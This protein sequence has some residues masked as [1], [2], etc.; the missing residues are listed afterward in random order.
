MK[1]KFFLFLLLIFGTY[2]S[3]AQCEIN[4]SA[5]PSSIVC[6]E[7]AVLT[8]FGSSTGQLVLN[9]DFNSGGFGSGWNSTPGAVNFS[10]P[11]SS[12][13]IDGTTHAWMDNNTSVPRA[14]IS[15]GYDLSAATAGVSICFDMLF[16]TQGDAAPC[17]GPDEPDEGVYLQ[18]STDGGATWVTIHYFDPN[19]GNDPQLTNWNNWCFA[20]PAVAITSNTMFQWYQDADSGQD[21][22]HWGI[23]NV[24]IFMNDANAEVIWLHDG[25]SYG[26][27]NPGGDNPTPVTPTTTTTYTAQITTGSGDVCTADITVIVTDPVYDVTVSAN[28]TTIC[29]GDCATIVGSAQII[30][31]PGG[32]ET[33]ENSEVSVLSG[34]PS[35]SDIANIIAPCFSFS[36]CNCPD[37][38]SVSIGQSCPAIFDAT[39][40][41]NINVTTLN[42][43]TLPTSSIETVCIDFAQMISGDFSTY[44][45]NLI[46][47]DGTSILL[48]NIGDLSGTTLSNVCFDMSASSYI[49]SGSSPYT[50]SWLPAEP[51]GNLNGC[52]A[53]G[54]YTLQFSATYDYSSGVP[55]GGVATGVLNGWNITFDDPPIFA[56]VD[57]QWSPTTGLSDPTSINTD[58]CPTTSTDYTLTLSNGTPG[59]PIHEEV[60]SIIVNPCGGCVPPNLIISPLSACSP[61]TVDLNSAIGAGSDPANLTFYASQ[62][63]AQNDVNAISSVVGAS[64][65]YWV[66]AEDS[67]DPSCYMEYEIVV[68]I[69]SLSISVST[70][71]ENCGAGD[72][73]ISITVSNGSGNYEYSVDG[74]TTTQTGSSF[75]GL[76]A[77]TYSIV[78]NDLTTGCTATSTENISNLGGPS[79][80]NLAITDPSCAGVCDGSITATVSGGTPPYTYSWTDGS[81]SS[82]GTNSPTISGLCSGNYNLEVSDAAGGTTQ[83]FYDDF[84]TGATGWTLNDVMGA[85]GADPNYFVV[86][87]D[88]G[89]VAPGGCGVASNGDATLHV[90]SVFNPSGGAAYDAGGLCGILFCP[91]A[92]R[93]AETPLISTIGQTGLTLNFDYIAGGDIPND[94]ATVW[95]NDGFGWTQLGGA[96]FSGTGAC[97]PQ[98]VWTAFSSALPVSCENISNLQIAIRWQNNDDGAGSDPSVAI[99]NIEI[100]TNSAASCSA[101]QMATLTDPP[102]EDASFTLTDFCAGDVNAA[103]GIITPGGTFTFNPAPG[104]GSTINTSTG[105]IA[106]GVVG[107]TYTVEYTTPGSCSAS[108]TQ[109]VTVNGI[110]YTAVTNDENCGSADGSID[111]SASDGSGNYSY[112]IDNGG[113]TQSI[114][115]FSGLTSGVY[116]VV[117]TDVTN[118]C[119]ISGTENVGSIGGPSIDN[120]SV[121][122]PS[123]NGMCDGE[124]TVSVSGGQPPYTYQWYDGSGNQIG[125]NSPTITGLCGGNYSVEVSDANGG[126]S[127]TLNTNTGFETGS[128]A[129]CDCPTGYSCNN[130]AGQVFDGN[131]PVY[132]PGNTGCVGGTTNYT[133]SLGANGGSGYVYFYAG[134]DYLSTG[135]YTFA[136]GETVELCVYYSGPQGSG[137]SGQNT[138]NSNFSFGVDGTQVGPD[139]LVPVNTGW[140]QFCFTVTMTPGNHTFEIL[141]GGAAQYVIWFDDFTILDISGGGTNCPAN[142]NFTLTEPV[143]EDPSFN[144]TD[145]CAGESNGA[146]GIASPGGTF[147]FNPNPSDG[148]SINASTGEITNGVPG[149]TYTI[150]YTTS[151]TCPVNA[152][153]T[154][155]VNGFTYSSVVTD[156]TCSSAN[157]SI[158]LT[159]SGGGA[160]FEYSIDNGTTTQ[161]GNTFSN[162]IAGNYDVLIVDQSTGCSASGVETIANT[163]VPQIDVID[164]TDETCQGLNNGSIDVS[165]VSGGTGNYS[166][167]WDIIPDPG[168]AQV[169]NLAPGTYTVTVT[170][171]VS[172]CSTTSTQTINS[173]VNCCDMAIDQL[174]STDVLCNGGLDGTID[175]T[176][177][178]GNG[179]VTFE[180]TDGTYSDNNTTGNFVSVPV[181]TY[182]VTLTNINGCTDQSQVTVGEPSSVDFTWTAGDITCFGGADGSISI[183][184]SGGTPNY[185][186]S[187]D[188][189]MTWSANSDQL[190]L[191]QA[192][193][194]VL[195]EDAN[196]CQTNVQSVSLNEAAEILVTTTI[197]NETCFNQCDGQVDIAVSGGSGVYTYNV[198]GA[199]TG[200][201]VTG[202]CGGTINYIIEDDNGCMVTGT[203]DV[204]SAQQITIDNI[205]VIDDDCDNSCVGEIIITSAQA[206]NYTLGGN[207]NTSGLFTGLC[208]DNYT[209]IL[210]DANG[211]TVTTDVVVGAG[212]SATANFAVLPGYV[213]I[214]NTEFQVINNSTNSDGYLWEI[215]GPENYSYTDGSEEFSLELP[216][217]PG[218]YTVCLVAGNS[219]GCPD[220]ICQS[221]IVKDEFLLFVPNSFTPNGDEYNNDLQV[222]ATG[223][224]EYGFNMQIFDR[225]GELIWETNDIS[226]FWDG[227]YN[228]KVVQSGTYTWK[229]VIKDPY[230]DERRD[231]VGHINVLK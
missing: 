130:D 121:T 230:T 159:T 123:C 109:T 211:C 178:G 152:S 209:V 148:S 14:L 29:V 179:T 110:T 146:T 31:D 150:E 138:A 105:E 53:N 7:S 39:L 45:L 226:I 98:G 202:L 75:N 13:G 220:T 218:A 74:G 137:A 222:Y 26:V 183:N 165:S 142:A 57:V 35:V 118:G 180:I 36:G 139:V 95:Y 196:G 96:L 54:I 42:G 10:N 120:I 99:N 19:G 116:N 24:Q 126:T 90:T 147:A 228:G 60:I 6:G 15:D 103:S 11:C 227:T 17:E 100:V 191:S 132:T 46:C 127:T 68:T 200:S 171:N 16:A 166:Y 43:V 41:M 89:G 92:D 158:E 47:P 91:Q 162:L 225:W 186:Y 181:G 229:I 81:G 37:G 221:V 20:V 177:S 174:S 176:Y 93:Q 55:S 94:Q 201:N 88:E 172:G 12:S 169:T 106:N 213:T 48:A 163:A 136:G 156:E 199:N 79:I 129:S 155:S 157:G 70:V 30:V 173:G 219:M 73:Q 215:T 44:E 59:C 193:Y 145:F 62:A 107:T 135:P 124:I 151:G 161:T 214:M 131:Q 82:V 108:S 9:E 85:E 58:A 101:T 76:T 49:T 112:S 119:Q 102:L 115:T 38:S 198:N 231:F 28:P 185:Q 77:N 21:Y 5:S 25:Y 206:T 217:V 23:D 71:P 32:I 40:D 33:Y 125:T 65:S 4:V 153:N 104:D 80:D 170:D 141:S 69:N 52:T 208:S 207:M 192:T 56:P 134:A 197:T 160:N 189:G 140:T 87:D 18:Y 72:G 84:E 195:V 175:V 223:I 149:T 22:D 1:A 63:N 194:D 97:T 111:L 66:R 86:N 144:L 190:G 224:D 167:S 210:S 114:G 133:S 117:I 64:G 204:V 8:A 3:N 113:T 122:D 61:A 205:S 2:F 34:I 182:T 216:P 184:P 51:F 67:G 188:N 212:Y 203:F 50:G 164:V 128:G 27:G 83:V 187:I 168:T 143:V 78:V 154:V